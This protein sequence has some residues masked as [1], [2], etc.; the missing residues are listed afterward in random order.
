MKLRR[1]KIL[2]KRA[3]PPQQ[4]DVSRTLASQSAHT[5]GWKCV[6]VA[7]GR[8]GNLQCGRSVRPRPPRRRKPKSTHN[9]AVVESTLKMILPSRREP[10]YH[11]VFV[12]RSAYDDL[13]QQFLQVGVITHNCNVG[14]IC[15]FL[16]MWYMHGWLGG[17]VSE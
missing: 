9:P 8:Y 11:P 15:P 13:R 16:G 5:L 2:N 14:Q 17:F 6:L 12:P 10:S 7:K 1:T 3:L 4:C